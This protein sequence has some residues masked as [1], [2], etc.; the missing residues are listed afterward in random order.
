[1]AKSDYPNIWSVHNL[2]IYYCSKSTTQVGIAS[3]TENDPNKVLWSPARPMGLPS[4]SER[5]KAAWLVF[6]GKADAV[7]WPGQ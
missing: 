2:V 5:F 7:K 3:P 1:M 4:L 6:T